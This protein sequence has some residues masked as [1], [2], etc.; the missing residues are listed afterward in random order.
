MAG[1]SIIIPVYNVEKY[2]K[3]CLDSVATQTFQDFEVIIVDDGS[4]DDSGR[5]VDEYAAKYSNFKAIHQENK[6]LSAARNVG[7]QAANS[8]YICFVDSDD[9]IDK[10]F[11][12][13]FHHEVV[14]NEPD[15]IICGVTVLSKKK[16]ENKI[17]NEDRAEII[18]Y[19]LLSDKWANWVWNKCFRRK[20]FSEFAF[21][22]GKIFEDMYFVGNIIKEAN[23]ITCINRP[24]YFY[25]CCND[26]SITHN[27]TA[28][29]EYK[30]IE[31]K[32]YLK[33][34]AIDNG[35]LD[36]SYIENTIMNLMRTC[37]LLDL[38]DGTLD[39]DK[40]EFLKDYL[41]RNRNY[42]KSFKDQFWVSRLLKDSDFLCEMYAKFRF[43]KLSKK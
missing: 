28:Q 33:Q 13:I 42:I 26:T 19:N 25:N 14:K 27:K 22:D 3:R 29:H 37:L 18:K 11:L 15:L 7:I 24:L 39:R 16:T 43:R 20:S 32:L 38:V 40:R 12:E 2:I 35:I 4:K 17:F 9:Y 21:M 36:A 6:G 10:E 1:F 23:R 30:F 41:V 31:A 5:I 34:K 8:E